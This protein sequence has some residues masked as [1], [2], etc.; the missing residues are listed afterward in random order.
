MRGT[1]T[2]MSGLIDLAVTLQI[3]NK[4]RSPLAPHHK[5]LPVLRKQE[6]LCLR[7]IRHHVGVVVGVH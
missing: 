3:D 1:K 2:A 6:E 7:Y 5:F 4:I